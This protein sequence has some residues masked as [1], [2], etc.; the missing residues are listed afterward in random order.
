ME[1]LLEG[2][3]PCTFSIRS[4]QRSSLKFNDKPILR[5]AVCTVVVENNSLTQYHFIYDV[6][7]GQFARVYTALDDPNKVDKL[8]HFKSMSD[9]LLN[10]GGLRFKSHDSH[11]RDMCD[12]MV[13]A[14]TKA[15][16]M[17][18]S[19]GP[20]AALVTPNCDPTRRTPLF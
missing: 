18:D 9:L 13:R 2:E 5:T 4:S 6:S 7:N 12:F 17:Y 14:A 11:V 15:E 1:Y 10:I 19:I 8:R 16:Q 20:E 3:P